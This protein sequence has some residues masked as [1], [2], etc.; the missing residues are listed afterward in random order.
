MHIE[1]EAPLS[2]TATPRR[3]RHAIRKA[4]GRMTAS[5]SIVEGTAVTHAP[6]WGRLTRHNLCFSRGLEAEDSR[7]QKKK[8]PLVEKDWGQAR[9]TIEGE[10]PKQKTPL[11]VK[12][13]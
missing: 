10:N 2:H 1:Q 13:A 12:S 4:R 6:A 7:H 8:T 11:N 9:R 3:R 5:P